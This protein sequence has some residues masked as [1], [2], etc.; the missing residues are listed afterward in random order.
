MCRNDRR[1]ERPGEGPDLLATYAAMVTA[2]AAADCAQQGV[3]ARILTC[4][5]A[6]RKQLLAQARER[7]VGGRLRLLLVA[8]RALVGGRA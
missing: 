5:A 6:T 2:K 4:D 7:W 1:K 3:R 8:A